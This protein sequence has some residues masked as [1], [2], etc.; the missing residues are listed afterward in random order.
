MVNHTYC[1]YLTLSRLPPVC[2]DAYFPTQVSAFQSLGVNVRGRRGTFSVAIQ[3]IQRSVG[4]T[5]KSVG[6]HR[7]SPTKLTDNL[8]KKSVKKSAGRFFCLW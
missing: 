2:L 6:F 7:F 1:Y 4:V 5:P 3:T 8:R